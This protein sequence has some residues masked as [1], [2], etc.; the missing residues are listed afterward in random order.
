M[1]T[2][3]ICVLIWLA[4]VVFLGEWQQ[5]AFPANIRNTVLPDVSH[6]AQPNLAE[7]NFLLQVQAPEAKA[8]EMPWAKTVLKLQQ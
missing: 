4:G 1:H 5:R 7:T 2:H 8:A 6:V 3:R